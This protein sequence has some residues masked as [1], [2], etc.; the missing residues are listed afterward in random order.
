MS[1][2]IKSQ[3]KA[4]I[5]VRYRADENTEMK[6]IMIQPGRNIVTKEK[7]EILKNHGGF[8]R[9]VNRDMITINTEGAAAQRAAAE[10]DFG[11]VET[12]RGQEDGKDIIKEYALA[13]D[14]VL[15][16]K[17][18]IDNMIVMFREQY[19]EK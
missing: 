7:Y 15:N 5:E 11:Y 2:V 14:I 9:L 10:P 19:K 3:S 12:L 8:N 1:V 6:S 17:N 18:T 13:W 16:K 4:T